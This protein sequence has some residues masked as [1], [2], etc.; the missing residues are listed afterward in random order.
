MH[1]IHEDIPYMIQS[2]YQYEIS[3]LAFGTLLRDGVTHVLNTTYLL[4]EVFV[5]L[6]ADRPEPSLLPSARPLHQALGADG[7]AQIEPA[8]HQRR[9]RPGQA[10]VLRRSPLNLANV[11][12][13][14]G[15]AGG[16]PY[17]FFVPSRLL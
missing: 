3:S 6:S 13:Q 7:V 2:T 14:A 15:A 11:H 1:Y 4:G 16:W 8:A 9:F 12:Q 10:G 17:I 5:F